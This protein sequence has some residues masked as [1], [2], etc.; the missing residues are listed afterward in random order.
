MGWGCQGEGALW[1]P[2]LSLA[3]GDQQLTSRSP[4]D[5]TGI[6]TTGCPRG[7]PHQLLSA[8]SCAPQA[9]GPPPAAAGCSSSRR[10]QKTPT[11]SPGAPS[12]NSQSPPPAGPGGGFLSGNPG[13]PAKPRTP[14][15]VGQGAEGRLW[16]PS[17]VSWA[18][19][20]GPTP[21]ARACRLPPGPG[22]GPSHRV[23]QAARL[24]ALSLA[25]G[26]VS[27]GSSRLCW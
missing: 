27:Q 2:A 8:L 7:S 20:Q 26:A 24:W 13:Q 1:P 12:I 9:P 10:P 21:R 6:K 14:A 18:P 25:S 17:P 4:Q 23:D 22:P 15:G 11:A 3:P 19:L 16:G 5:M